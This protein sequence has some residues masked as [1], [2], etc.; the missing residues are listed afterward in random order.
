MKSYIVKRLFLAI[1]T[2]VGITIITFC[3]IQLAPGTPVERNLQLDQGIQSEE[4]TKEIV[5]QTKKLYGLDKP[6]HIRYWIWL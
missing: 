6:I 3:I 2:L 1:P 5:E 4:I